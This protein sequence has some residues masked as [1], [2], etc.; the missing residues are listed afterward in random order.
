[1]MQDGDA[2]DTKDLYS[3]I[4]REKDQKMF[5]EKLYYRKLWRSQRIR[6]PSRARLLTFSRYAKIISSLSEPSSF[7]LD[8][9]CD[10]GIFAR[11]LESGGHYNLVGIDLANRFKHSSNISFV[12]AE[13]THLPFRAKSFDAIFARKFASIPD[14][15][16][17][18][19][20][21]SKILKA[22]GKLLIEVKNVQSFGTNSAISAQILSPLAHNAFQ[23]DSMR[24]ELYNSQN[25]GRLCLHSSNRKPDFSVQT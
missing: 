11:M 13:N 23:K 21:L 8:V 5:E 4:G 3:E 7:I 25:Q 18:L 10:S 17:S 24:K 12:V 20:E 14:T 15:S 2:V 19:G 9:G 1:M 6:E 22:D 16:E